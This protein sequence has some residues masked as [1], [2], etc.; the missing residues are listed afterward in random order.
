VLQLVLE[1]VPL[2]EPEPVPLPL[3]EPLPLPQVIDQ[4][5]QP[6]AVPFSIPVTWFVAESVTVGWPSGTQVLVH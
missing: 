5:D 6:V 1:D 2:A 4:N 3:P